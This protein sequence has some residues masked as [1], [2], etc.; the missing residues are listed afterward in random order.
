MYMDK[1]IALSLNTLIMLE[2]KSLQG[3]HARLIFNPSCTFKAK[4]KKKKKLCV[5][6]Y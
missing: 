3:M 5:L 6:N 4:K 1:L 2:T